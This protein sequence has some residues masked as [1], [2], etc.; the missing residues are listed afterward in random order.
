MYRK[1]TTKEIDKAMIRNLMRGGDPCADLTPIIE[2]VM[3]ENDNPME[4]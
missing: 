2:E 1:P 3:R 4:E